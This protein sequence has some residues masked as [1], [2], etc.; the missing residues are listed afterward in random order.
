MPLT[1]FQRNAAQAAGQPPRPLPGM[2]QQQYNKVVMD[3]KAHVDSLVTQQIKNWN[4]AEDHKKNL[5]FR[6]Q[7]HR[8]LEQTRIAQQQ[9]TFEE[10]QRKEEVKKQET[11][12]KEQKDRE[13]L[14]ASKLSDL[15]LKVRQGV[16]TE[17][18]KNPTTG[19]DELRF[20][21]GKER[22][23][24][25]QRQLAEH[26]D[27]IG[28][29]LPGQQGK[30]PPPEDQTAHFEKAADAVLKKAGIAADVGMSHIDKPTV[31]KL[32]K[33]GT[34]VWNNI[35][36]AQR[37]GQ[38]GEAQGISSFG[39]LVDHLNMVHQGGTGMSLKQYETYKKL[40][41]TVNPALAQ[42]FMVPET[43]KE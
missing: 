19:K 1:Q 21:P 15:R 26:A 8:I 32:A 41:A 12:R 7:E 20:P 35:P 43:Q 14:K 23:A 38:L 40:L 28:V 2:T 17:V 13:E 18:W 10:N 29:K 6:A 27:D 9:R 33:A 42:H 3:H 24:E 16:I 22:E 4:Q 34:E 39:R 25:I 5:A 36:W 11:L 31:A 30:P 37:G